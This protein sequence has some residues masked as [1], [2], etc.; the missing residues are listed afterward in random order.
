[1][2]KDGRSFTLSGH[3]DEPRPSV[4]LIAKSIQPSQ[5]GLASHIALSDS[6]QL[7]QDS[8]LVFSVRALMPP[9]FTRTAQI[10]VATADGAFS[11]LLSIGA[12]TMMLADAHVAVA[13]LDPAKAFGPSAFGPL[14]FRVVA[15][16]VT[17]SWLPLATLVRL[18]RLTSLECPQTADVACRLS[19]TDLFLIDSVSADPQFHSPVQVPDGFP[20]SSLPVPHPASGELFVRL[21]DDPAIVNAATLGTQVLA[22]AP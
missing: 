9:A 7:P 6:D 19:G 13:R 17:G 2:L 5:A 8:E 3:I 14:R 1:M 4:T 18:P 16:G 21:R 22:I 15:D 12:G 10:E 11:S 20:G